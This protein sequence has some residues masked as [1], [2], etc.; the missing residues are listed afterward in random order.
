LY[1]ENSNL[2]EKPLT[3]LELLSIAHLALYWFSLQISMI[4]LLEVVKLF[5]CLS[6]HLSSYTIT[7]IQWVN[8]IANGLSLVIILI[9]LRQRSIFYGFIGINFAIVGLGTIGYYAYM[10]RTYSRKTKHSIRHKCEMQWNL[11]EYMYFGILTCAAA[12]LTLHLIINFVSVGIK[13]HSVINSIIALLMVISVIICLYM[14]D[15]LVAILEI[16]VI[17][18]RPRT[19]SAVQDTEPP[20]ELQQFDIKKQAI[21]SKNENYMITNLEPTRLQ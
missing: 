6:R 17:S 18:R 16:V 12:S 21:K 5:I 9:V 20:T 13:A 8:F 11:L 19:Q 15:L 2:F 4:W 14:C 3:P 7:A 1:S 10:V